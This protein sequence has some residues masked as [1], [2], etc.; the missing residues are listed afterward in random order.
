MRSCS[1]LLPSF[2]LFSFLSLVA[3]SPLLLDSLLND[4]A[5]NPNPS[6]QTE[7]LPASSDS[8]PSVA[9]PNTVVAHFMV[10][11]VFRYTEE[12]WVSEMTL[13]QRYG[14]DGFALNIGP[15]A[16]QRDQIV[17]AFSAGE[18][19]GFKL[20]ISFDMSCI[21]CV[22]D[23]DKT[24]LVDYIND[25]SDKPAY[26]QFNGKPLVSAFSGQNC[27]FGA[28]DPNAGW[29]DIVAQTSVSFVPCFFVQPEDLPKWDSLDGVS[30]WNSGW[31]SG[32]YDIDFSRDDDWINH[33]DGRPYMASVSPWFFTHY[34]RNSWNKNFVY[35]ADDFLLSQRWE[36][37]VSNRDRIPIV[38]FISWN[39]FGE[40][41]YIGPVLAN[42]DQPNSQAWVNGF[43][44]QAWLEV[45]KF[46]IAAYKTGPYPRITQDR[47]VMWSRL[48]PTDA[49]VDTDP[50][51]PPEHHDW[52]EDS[53]WAVAFL[54][55]AAK[56]TVYCG[57][58]SNSVS[59]SSGG[60]V[61]LKLP[62]KS[63]CSVSALI[64]RN[65]DRVVDFAPANFDFSTTPSTYN[66][67]AFVAASP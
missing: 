19:V 48:F 36:L 42:T 65:G 16:W 52:V 35:R 53:L 4:D 59:A 3:G 56:F 62:L 46:Y 20:Y 1:L 29:R 28:S 38:Q 25:F 12:D 33:L 60:L 31:P 5:S 57:A 9:S 67:N 61:K 2:A 39:D 14:F 32:D 27:A 11:N 54:T 63:D 47:V 50:V 51:G 58:S 37:L 66:F 8:S 21:S 23:T 17:K 26:L 55:D 15:D 6:S 49:E 30:N 18:K 10:G 41:H 45:V 34:G 7:S 40:S 43:D 22:S 44:H 13:A 24:L 64:E